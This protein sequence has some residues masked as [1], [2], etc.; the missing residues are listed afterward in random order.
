MT[1]YVKSFLLD[2]GRVEK[3][4]IVSV[5]ETVTVKDLTFENK[6]TY[7]KSVTTGELYLPFDNP[8]VNLDSDY[9]IY[10]KEKNLLSTKEIVQIRKKYGL[11]LRSFAKILGIGYSTLSKIE[12][13]AVQSNEH[14]ALL[15]LASNPYSFY[16]NLV[17]PKSELLSDK[18]LEKINELVNPKAKIRKGDK[19]WVLPKILRSKQFIQLS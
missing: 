3:F 16:N 5:N 1:K 12:N 13:G 7:W 14:D 11:S 6:H 4:E 8:D 9:A 17:L 2:L 10:K 15:R 18:E 19:K